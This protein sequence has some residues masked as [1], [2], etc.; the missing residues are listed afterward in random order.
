MY[1]PVYIVVT[2]FFPSHKI[3]RGAFFFDFTRALARTG[4]YD[5]RVFVP[6]TSASECVDYEYNGVQVHTF[7]YKKFK[8]AVAPFVYAPGNRKRFMAA[9]ERAKIDWGKVAI[10]HAHDIG[11]VPLSKNIKQRNPNIK[12]LLHFHNGGQPFCLRCGRAG[13]IPVYSALHYIWHRH[14]FE[15]VDLPVFVSKRQQSQFGRWYPDGYLGPTED[16]LKS[17][18]LGRWIRPILLNPSYVLY[19]GIDKS[20]FNKL[21]KTGLSDYRKGA[22][23]VIGDVANIIKTKDPMTL[24]RAL[25]LLKESNYPMN[26]W[27]C[28]LVG[29]GE[30]VAKC[31]EFILGKGLGDIVE[32]IKEVD[33][34]ELPNIYKS[35]DLFVLPSWVEGFGCA[36]VEAAGCG[37]PIM[38]CKGISVEEAIASEEHDKWLF[39]LQDYKSLAEK[40]KWF[41]EN[42]PRQTLARD[43]DIDKLMH[44]FIEYLSTLCP[45]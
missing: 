35:L 20:L 18:F 27:R 6:R 28:I 19:N 31:N 11:L 7:F 8:G 25:A 22:K 38:G 29:S 45:C 15:N 41:Y 42:R 12:I 16:I 17:A 39:P 26:G 43:F 10:F 14:W 13:V 5:V 4:K 21:P 30:D 23:F 37:V 1:K 34:T 32:I 36:Y 40:I 24:L 3:W 2:P 33:H 44:E 9:A